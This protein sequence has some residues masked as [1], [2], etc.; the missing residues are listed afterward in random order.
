MSNAWFVLQS[1]GTSIPPPKL[2]QH[3]SVVIKD[4]DKGSALV[5]FGGEDETGYWSNNLYI[6]DLKDNQ[7]KQIGWVKPRTASYPPKK[8][9]HSIIL[10]QKDLFIFG[11]SDN[12]VLGG[13][14]N[15]VYKLDLESMRWRTVDAIG[16]AP[17]GRTLH[18]CCNIGDYFYVFGGRSTRVG[19]EE[20]DVRTRQCFNDLY[21]FE[22]ADC[23]W[24]KM[25]TKG[26]A[27]S[28]RC[29]MSVVTDGDKLYIFG[30]LTSDTKYQSDVYELNLA[31]L[32]WTKL[33][34]SGDIPA[35]RERHSAVLDNSK[36]MIVYGGWVHGG[37]SN[38][39]YTLDLSNL[40]WVKNAPPS[41]QQ[42]ST[43]GD[44]QT[45][46][47]GHSAH[48]INGG[49]HMLVF[50]GKNQFWHNLSSCL[51][52][53]LTGQGYAPPTSSAQLVSSINNKFP[54]PKHELAIEEIPLQSLHQQQQSVSSPVGKGRT[55]NSPVLTVSPQRQQPV[56]KSFE[57]KDEE[58][59]A[60]EAERKRLKEEQ[61]ILEKERREEQARLEKERLEKERFEQEQQKIR[62]QERVERER[63]EEQE[64]LE[65]ERI[66]K[67]RQEQE[68]LEQER[69]QQ[70]SEQETREKAEQSR[71][72]QERLEVE[73]QERNERVQ[74]EQ[75]RIEKERLVEEERVAKEKSEK[76]R[77]D[78]E[79]LDQERTD[80]ERIER[81]RIE[82]EAQREEQTQQ[83][84]EHERL[85]KERLERE[86]QERL[87][88]EK[89]EQE[90]VEQ[91]RREQERIEKERLE[92]EE[93]ERLAN[94]KM[95]VQERVEQ[96]KIEQEPVQ[97]L[98]KVEKQKE[99][100]QQEESIQPTEHADDAISERLKAVENKEKLVNMNKPKFSKRTHKLSRKETNVQELASSL[101][102]Q[103]IVE[104]P[105]DS[106]FDDLEQEAKKIAAPV[107]EK[108][109]KKPVG[110]VNPFGMGRGGMGN[111]M[112]EMLAKRN[113]IKKNTEE[114]Q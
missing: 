49:R 20:R 112:Q 73:E 6:Y 13:G 5:I 101:Q 25:E 65:K 103:A 77:Q 81:E 18:A 19:K 32:R 72:E 16:E 66:H 48:L 17:T 50:G 24:T 28:P 46:R 75:Q 23:R 92:R 14:N 88:N 3:A 67:E 78:Q 70:L 12:Q 37:A 93:Q 11:G 110:A 33:E 1:S 8:D 59:R 2:Y 96:E 62:E 85:E 44:S 83:R 10:K 86:E 29:G 102:Q 22:M 7:W 98:E 54:G 87:T 55:P 53:D 31:S 64:R 76:E 45:R 52:Y 40:K 43:G 89:T 39:C 21:S 91:E 113:Q 68:R 109:E 42:D 4:D 9:G 97:S 114:S 61:E 63:R 71:I 90:R 107:E 57:D 104:L 56:E 100:P 108:Q 94:E 99:K 60:E 111:M 38:Q 80:Q 69:E 51:V 79:R 34:C 26:E 84:I 82:Q 36:R 74:A 106:K 35:G 15:F 41:I 30:G 27:P 47:Y 58:E 105:S 95:L